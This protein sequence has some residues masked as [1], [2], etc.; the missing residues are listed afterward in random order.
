MHFHSSQTGLLNETNINNWVPGYL[1]IKSMS[2]SDSAYL[3]T[4]AAHPVR[5]FDW[6]LAKWHRTHGAHLVRKFRKILPESTRFSVLNCDEVL[7]A[8]KI[9]WKFGD[10]LFVCKML[11]SCENLP[12][13]ILE[14]FILAPHLINH[15]CLSGIMA[16]EACDTEPGINNFNFQ[17]YNW[18]AS[19]KVT[20]YK[21][22]RSSSAVWM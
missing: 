13:A 4:E 1:I 8:F 2:N 9:F 15:V 10:E 5:E 16:C 21:T 22:S 19:L 7:S 12:A 20:S 18:A 3:L 14:I 11:Q 17:W 6:F